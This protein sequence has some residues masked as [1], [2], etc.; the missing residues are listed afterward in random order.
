MATYTFTFKNSELNLELVSSDKNFIENESEKWIRSVAKRSAPVNSLKNTYEEAKKEASSKV[1]QSRENNESKSKN[2]FSKVLEEKINKPLEQKIKEKSNTDETIIES[3]KELI[4]SKKPESLIDY[5]IV[6][7]YYL[8][9]YDNLDKYSLKQL[10]ALIIRY[11]K[12]PI[13]HAVMQNA[14]NQDLIKVIPDFTGLGDITEY[15]ITDNGENYF[16]SVL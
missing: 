4:A 7:A 15:T 10:N 1:R 16:L 2:N 12:K 11:T 9:N 14:I 3:I 6:A 5:L 8:S 13:D